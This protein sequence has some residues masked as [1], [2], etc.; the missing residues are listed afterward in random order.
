MI[1][2]TWL[3]GAAEG[4]VTVDLSDEEQAAKRAMIAAHRSQ[5]ATLAQFPVDTE[6]FRPAPAYDFRQPPHAGRLNYEVFGWADGEAWRS[7]AAQ[8]LL[9]LGI[10][11]VDGANGFVAV[12]EVPA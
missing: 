10:G 2:S 1:V 6:R 12:I 9:E 4:A 8:A 11:S 7:A 5:S 3:P